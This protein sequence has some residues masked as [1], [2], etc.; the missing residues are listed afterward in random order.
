MILLSSLSPRHIFNTLYYTIHY[1]RIELYI[2]PYSTTLI[3]FTFFFFN[4]PATPEI[5]PL[6]L[7]DPLPICRRSTPA[8]A[9]APPRRRPT[10]R[11][12]RGWA[13][14]SR[15]PGYRPDS[16]ARCPR[17]PPHHRAARAPRRRGGVRDRKST[18]LNSSHGYISYA[19]F[20][21]KKKK[22]K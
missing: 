20:C 13:R 15:A 18:R 19:V 2:P 11:S 3:I 6:S 21:L 16:A 14:A 5:Y 7:P 9:Q 12:G 17:T 4:D 8:N 10:R 1:Q 22:N